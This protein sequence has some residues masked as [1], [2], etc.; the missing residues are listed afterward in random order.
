MGNSAL[1]GGGIGIESSV[2]TCNGTLAVNSNRAEDVGGGLDAFSGSTIL[3]YGSA[4]FKANNAFRGGGIVVQESNLSCHGNIAYMV[5]SAAQ[6]GGMAIFDANVTC[7]SS[8]LFENN[9]ANNL[10]DGL[11]IVSQIRTL[12]CMPIPPW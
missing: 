2:L 7:D 5:N 9:T 3:F 4:V 6:G 1:Y 12:P 11:L 8:T 10:G